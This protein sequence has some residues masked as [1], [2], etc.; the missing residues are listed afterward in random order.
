MTQREQLKK[1]IFEKFKDGYGSNPVSGY[2]HYILK[3][4]DGKLKIEH[5][6]S[7]MF[8]NRGEMAIPPKF[9]KDAQE[10]YDDMKLYFNPNA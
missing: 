8:L 9:Y 10:M 5:L 7:G 6:T 4:K 2:C 3:D 1:L